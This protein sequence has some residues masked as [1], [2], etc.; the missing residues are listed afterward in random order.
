MRPTLF[1]FKLSSKLFRKL[2]C[3]Q[4]IRYFYQSISHERL[5]L[6]SWDEAINEL[7]RFPPPISQEYGSSIC[8]NRMIKGYDLQIIIPVYR[9]CGF[10]TFTE[11]QISHSADY[12]Q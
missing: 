11:Y 6:G 4:G 2:G 10:C 3:W 5:N 7:A 9:L 8:Q 1:L 12:R